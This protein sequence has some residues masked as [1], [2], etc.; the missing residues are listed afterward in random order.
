[1][2]IKVWKMIFIIE[3]DNYEEW[4]PKETFRQTELLGEKDWNKRLKQAIED[5]QLNEG[6]MVEYNLRDLT[7]AQIES[8]KAEEIV[9]IFEYD[10]YII[11]YEYINIGA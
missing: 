8:M 10:G 9:E 5:E 11:D 2:K 7:D 1:M 6:T 4:L 3:D